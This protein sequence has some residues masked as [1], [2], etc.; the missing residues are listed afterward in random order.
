MKNIVVVGS[1]SGAA[2]ARKLEKL[3]PDSHRVILIE[4][5]G[6]AYWPV[7]ALRSG[8]REGQ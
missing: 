5:N 3:L 6:F 7:S 1:A 2:V 8:V 4:K